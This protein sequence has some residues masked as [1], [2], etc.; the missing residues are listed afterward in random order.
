MSAHNTNKLVKYGGIG[1]AALL[2][3]V[4]VLKSCGN[5]SDTSK[6]NTLLN[7]N[8]IHNSASNDSAAESLDTLTSELSSV[9]KQITDV[10][11]ENEILR[12][13]NAL[14]Q[15]A[16]TNSPLGVSLNQSSQ[17]NSNPTPTKGTEDK[18]LAQ[19]R[20]RS[21]L[22]SP[23]TV[24]SN[25]R[26]SSTPVATTDVP[27]PS[28]NAPLTTITDLTDAT[29]SKADA[30]INRI[31]AN[32]SHGDGNANTNSVNA[33]EA[34]ANKK[35]IPYY[36]I[37]A[38]ATSVHDRLMTSLV[39]RIPIKGVVA[40]PYPFKIVISDDTLAANGLRVPH[41]KQMIVSGYSE[42][43]LVT[44]SVSGWVTSLT[45]VFQDGT[46]Y[47]VSSNDNNIG[48]FTKDNALGYLSDKFGNPFIRGELI[49]NAPEYL[50]TKVGLSVA[51]GFATAYAQDQTTNQMNLVGGAAS[52]VTGSAK[53]FMMGQGMASGA[54]AASQW[55]D[56]R[57]QSSFDAIYVP[58]IDSQGQPIEIAVNFSKEIT[59][60]YDPNGRKVN[61]DQTQNS[62]NA[63]RSTL[64]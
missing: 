44:S 27:T 18:T 42:G 24:L 43:D 16:G 5:N 8:T 10:A 35:P 38:N 13:Q 63:L 59:I 15:N 58:T 60:N 21:A 61:Y 7:K 56:D 62:A 37:P 45:F 32:A 46:I 20:I 64:D 39:G 11:K 1:F 34:Q 54:N 19:Y 14:L 3:S 12:Q 28:D 48:K 57:A 17:N 31:N 25:D 51:S 52:T 4:I 2:G 49:S 55:F 9:K 26:H 50:G 40:D 22:A 30:L 29:P 33:G 6:S 23:S 41:L 36:T 47:N 53:K